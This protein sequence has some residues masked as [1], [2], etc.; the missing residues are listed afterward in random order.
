MK[1]TGVELQITVWFGMQYVCVKQSPA[2][3]PKDRIK[4]ICTNGTPDVLLHKMTVEC[5]LQATTDDR[6][7]RNE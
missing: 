3:K 6:Q 4:Y 5:F 1:S 2:G 7:I